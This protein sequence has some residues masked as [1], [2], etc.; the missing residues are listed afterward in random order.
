M[1]IVDRIKELCEIHHT[2]F[3]EVER[4]VG[5][6]NGQIRRWDNASPKLENIEK[7]ADYFGVTVDYLRGKDPEEKLPTDLDKI[8]DNMMSFDGKPMTENDREA[9]RAYLEGRFSSK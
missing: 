5:I 7:V 8:L 3:A 1:G 6:S 2:N 4:R 9:I